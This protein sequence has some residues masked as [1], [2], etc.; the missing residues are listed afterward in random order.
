M[1]MYKLVGETIDLGAALG[2]AATSITTQVSAALPAALGVG[3]AIIAV[4][5][6]WK[7]FKRFVRG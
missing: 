5:V 1:N 6:G 4:T 2:T 7:I 3:A